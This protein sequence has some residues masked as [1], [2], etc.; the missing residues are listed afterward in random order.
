MSAKVAKSRK[1]AADKASQ[2]R[3][4][5][6]IQVEPRPESR[7]GPINLFGAHLGPFLWSPFWPVW[8]TFLF[9][10]DPFGAHFT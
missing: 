8:D 3:K 4:S 5:M 6:L 7:L 10:W 2:K 1:A 9:I